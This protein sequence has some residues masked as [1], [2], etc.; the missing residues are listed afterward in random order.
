MS[1]FFTYFFAESPVDEKFKGHHKFRLKFDVTSIPKGE[2]LKGAE[3]IVTREATNNLND[4]KEFQRIL[5]KDIIR[6]GISRKDGPITRIIDSKLIDT[7]NNYTISFDISMAAARWIENPKTNHGLLVTVLNV[8]H[9]KGSLPS[10]H[11]RLRRNADNTFA[12]SQIQPL[13]FT[14]TDDGRNTQKMSLRSKRSPRRSRKNNHEPCRRLSMYV[15]FGEVGWSDWIVAPSGYD[16]FYCHG[17]CNFPL[18]EHLNTTN[19]AIVQTLMNSVSPTTVPKPCCIPTHLNSISMLY[20]DDEQ[21]VVL[22]NY[23]DMVVNGCGCR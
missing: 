4:N 12:W 3:L 8:G 19:H 6:P 18:A 14:Y 22:K 10:R 5:I 7:T 20:L 15:D 1:K 13:L 2:S 21:K 9:K 17:E 16:A 11:I 23:K